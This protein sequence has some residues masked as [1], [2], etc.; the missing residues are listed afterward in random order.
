M[1]QYNDGS[2][3]GIY[4]AKEMLEFLSKGIPQDLTCTHWGTA[5]HLEDV[6]KGKQADVDAL[7]ER[8]DNLE[9]KMYGGIV[10]VSP[11]ILKILK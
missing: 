4:P 3:G 8:V 7:K 2:F 6:K 9:R 11:D 5:Q 10:C 1:N